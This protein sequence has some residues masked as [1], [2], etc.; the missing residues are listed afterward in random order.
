MG[1]ASL[2][3]A[4]RASVAIMRGRLGVHLALRGPECAVWLRAVYVL[5]EVLPA[6]SCIHLCIHMRVDRHKKNLSFYSS[7]GF[8][9][10]SVSA[11]T[12]WSVLNGES[13]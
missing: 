11:A 10:P 12:V 8:F 2:I 9:F 4:A 5:C 3:A 7:V 1:A 6:A 13:G